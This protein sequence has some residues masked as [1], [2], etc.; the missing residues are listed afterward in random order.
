MFIERHGGHRSITIKEGKDEKNMRL[1]KILVRQ[2]PTTCRV[3]ICHRTRQGHVVKLVWAFD[4][5]IAEVEHLRLA[6]EKGVEGVV[7]AVSYQPITSA[8]DLWAGLTFEDRHKLNDL[9]SSSR[10]I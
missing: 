8:L 7:T 1:E 10:D 2:T 6:A 3:T 5:R 4:K 9:A